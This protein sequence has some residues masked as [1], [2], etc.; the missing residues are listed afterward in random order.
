[1]ANNETQIKMKK[2]IVLVAL[3]AIVSFGYAQQKDT[4]VRKSNV[5]VS[6]EKVD[7]NT[8]T[9]KKSSSKKS[10]KDKKAM[11]TKTGKYINID[12][13]RYEILSRKLTRGPRQGQVVYYIWKDTPKGGYPKEL[14]GFTL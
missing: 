11:Y 3:M 13:V 5:K 4:T 9:L 1:M 6:Y 8:Y 7:A 12:G 2:L 14:E 10:P